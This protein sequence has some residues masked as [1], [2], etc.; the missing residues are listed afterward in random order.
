MKNRWSVLRI[1]IL[2]VCLCCFSAGCG[3]KQNNEVYGS[4]LSGLGD[5]DAYAFLDMD[6]KNNVLVT[7]DMPYDEGAENQAAIY[8]NVYYAIGDSAGNPGTI[9]SGG[10]AYPLKFTK[11]G[12]YTAS[13]HSVEKYMI[14]E[15]DFSLILDIG[16]YE[17]FDESGKVTYKSEKNGVEK[18]ITESEY[19]KM[20]EEYGSAQIIHF[21]YGADGSMNE[22]R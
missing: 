9:M 15:K 1:I 16:V 10:T 17:I 22:Y 6:Y 4:I 2:S 14:S 3:N 5:N 11:S 13:G 12:I 18:D 21:S 8:C 7:T 19:Q 20:L